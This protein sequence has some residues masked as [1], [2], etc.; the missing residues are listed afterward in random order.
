MLTPNIT[1]LTYD[2]AYFAE[3]ILITTHVVYHMFNLLTHNYNTIWHGRQ[4]TMLV[5]STVQQIIKNTRNFRFIRCLCV[6]ACVF[7]AAFINDKCRKKYMCRRGFEDELFSG[8]CLE[9]TFSRNVKG[10]KN[11]S[12]SKFRTIETITCL[13]KK[14]TVGKSTAH[15]RR[16]YTPMPLA[17]RPCAASG[18]LWQTRVRIRVK[19]AMKA[20]TLCIYRIFVERGC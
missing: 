9:S 2:S 13:S 19:N 16:G 1:N 11:Q 14:V 17:T 18:R 3:D 8:A 7:L 10:N 12:I 5:P 20:D 6:N 15:L 4:S